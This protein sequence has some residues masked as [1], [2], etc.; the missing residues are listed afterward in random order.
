MNFLRF[1]LL[2]VAF[3]VPGTAGASGNL[4]SNGSFETGSFSG[5]QRHNVPNQLHYPCVI[6]NNPTVAGTEP[7]GG[8]SPDPIGTRFLVCVANPSNESMTQTVFLNPGVYSVGFTAYP[9]SYQETDNEKFIASVGNTTVA[10]INSANKAANQWYL[11]TGT[12]QINTAG[13]YT[14]RFKYLVAGQ[15]GRDIYVD[16]LY[17][18]QVN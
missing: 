16:R 5:W 3:V 7:T 8:L 18:V 9:F 13:T 6:V 11:V 10:S 15:Y 4:L 2:A 17:M 1:A 14:V 12:I